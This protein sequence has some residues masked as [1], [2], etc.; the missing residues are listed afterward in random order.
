MMQLSRMF[1]KP[2]RAGGKTR[3]PTRSN[4]NLCCKFHGNWHGNQL[5]ESDGKNEMVRT[6]AVDLS[7]A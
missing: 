6:E 1:S 3:L 2:P 4:G 5:S 7:S